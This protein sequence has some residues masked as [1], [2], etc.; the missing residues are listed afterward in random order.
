V[1]G[2]RQ[3]GV[4]SRQSTCGWAAPAAVVLALVALAMSVTGCRDRSARQS[5]ALVVGIAVGP[6]NL[7]PRVG[8]DEASQRVHQLLHAS[9]VRL[10]DRLQVVPEVAERLEMRDATTY[11][12]R[13][14]EGVRFHDGSPLDAA[15]VAF[16][17]RSFLDK[18]F[19]SPRKGAYAQLQAVDVEDA[20]TVVF[21]LKE[22]FASFPV[23][24]V[25]GIVPEGTPAG[26]PARIG[27]GPYRFVRM[28]ADDRVELAAN[29]DYFE[30]PP[31]NGGVVLRVIPDDTMRGLELR[32]GALDLVVNDIA[33]D[34]ARALE[35]ED[36]LQVVTAPGLDYAYVGMNLR[37]PVLKDVRVRR[38]LGLAIDAGAIIAH[39]RRGL[40]VPAT[41]IIPPMSW[42]HPADLRP[43]PHDPAEA[44]RLLDAAGYPDPDGP[45]PQPRLRLTLKTSTA[46]FV[47]LQAAVLQ[48]DLARIGV[49]V[50]VRTQEFATLYADVL[51][52]RFQLFTL[53]WV[54][55]TD[56]D[57]LRR[58][59]HS[60]QMPP[61]GFNRG[62]FSDPAVDALIDA[63]TTNPDP[64][65]R[66][67][68]YLEVQRRISEAAPY[69]SL[70]TKV[71]VAVAQ[72]WVR[73][74]HLTP[75]ASFATLRNVEK[76]R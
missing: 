37:D 36:R 40:A 45:G 56:P 54:G 57:M 12:A 32:T 35:R 46:E 19:L 8:S 71:N 41:G 3:S 2:E 16:T 70:W 39:L 9:L 21:R 62:F 52:G 14:R 74:V 53:Q 63:A 72:P 1:S 69:V 31:L 20:R 28:Q 25:M 10:D 67:A 24:L 47:R 11:V 66:L 43:P 30:G 48:Q 51:K 13:L 75:Q 44:G 76:I 58:V 64:V 23:N 26:A 22:P 60:A 59:F 38:A 49:A 55:V 61:A 15:D 4:G 65:S 68:Q 7:D 73:N 18:A 5:D 27:A 42:A 33:P 29:R 6:T 17:F 34:I 50:D